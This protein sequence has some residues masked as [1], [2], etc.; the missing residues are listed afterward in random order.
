MAFSG[1]TDA[2]LD[3]GESPRVQGRQFPSKGKHI[4]R[5]EPF[6]CGRVNRPAHCRRDL[7]MHGKQRVRADFRTAVF[8]RDGFRCVTCGRAGKDRQGGDGHRK[9]HPPTSEGTLVPLDAHH[10][11]DRNEMPNGGYVKENGISVCDNGCHVL[12]EAY[13]RTGHAHPG[14]TP[15]ELYQRIGSSFEEAYRAST[16]PG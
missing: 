2:G 12:A 7:D 15:A 13:H 10:I 4:E 16:Q 3:T 8:T 6:A 11:T 1:H 5:V 9:Y 14:F